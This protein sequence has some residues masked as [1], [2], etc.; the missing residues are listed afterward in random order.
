MNLA[1]EK[2][3]CLCDYTI[4]AG[5]D[6]RIAALEKEN[7]ELKELRRNYLKELAKVSKS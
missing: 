3:C 2:E 6:R 5:T 1:E 7:E 4:V